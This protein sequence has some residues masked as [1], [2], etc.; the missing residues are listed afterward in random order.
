MKK[1]IAI[2]TI[3][4][5]VFFT[6]QYCAASSRFIRKNNQVNV[7]LKRVEFDDRY[8]LGLDRLLYSW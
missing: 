4:M 8:F 6:T 1:A 5:T 2:I 3:M 7:T